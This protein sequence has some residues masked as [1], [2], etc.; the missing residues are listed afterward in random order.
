MSIVCRDVARREFSLS[1]LCSVGMV[2]SCSC[3]DK[4]GEIIGILSGVKICG[5]SRS[6][7][8]VP[9]SVG[10]INKSSVDTWQAD[11]LISSPASTSTCVREDWLRSPGSV[12]SVAVASGSNIPRCSGVVSSLTVG[13]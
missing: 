2:I 12:Q 7:C 3:W 1:S 5:V 11:A 8:I 4:C 13:G 6:V 10:Y 9:R